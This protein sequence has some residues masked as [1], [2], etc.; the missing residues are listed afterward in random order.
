MAKMTKHVANRMNA[1]PIESM[2]HPRAV[3]EPDDIVLGERRPHATNAMAKVAVTPKMIL[4]RVPLWTASCWGMGSS[5]PTSISWDECAVD[6]SDD[7]P[8]S[9]AVCCCETLSGSAG[10]VVSDTRNLPYRPLAG[11]YFSYSDNRFP[12]K[13]G[14]P[15]TV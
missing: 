13:G 12:P 15:V 6:E 11:A 3:E 7:V 2:T 9:E 5:T 10:G 14:R 8:S 4:S 1:Q